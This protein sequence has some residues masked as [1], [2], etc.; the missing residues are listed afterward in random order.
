MGTQW[1]L[2]VL[3][4]P[5]RIAE[6][7]QAVLN[8]VVMQMSQWEPE[9]DISRFNRSAPSCWVM[10]P[11]EFV[12]V[13]E[14]ALAIS[15][16][17]GGAFD[18]AMGALTDMWGFG[19]ARPPVRTPDAETITLAMA[20]RGTVELDS[21]GLRARR[22]GKA[23]LDFSGIAKGYGV[24]LVAEWLL[25]QGVR[26]F[27]IEV[28]G[29]LRGHGLRPDRQPW[30]AD[31]ELPPGV[32]LPPLRVALHEMAIATSGDYRRWLDVD[33]RRHSHSI[34]PRNGQPIANGVRSVTV[35]HS[36]CMLADA[37]ATA[38]TV[39]GPEAG[40][41]LARSEGLAVQMVTTEEE[42]ISPALR[43]MLD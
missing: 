17:S 2:S 7:V 43:E 4:P 28:G 9:S 27:L 31:I 23:R 37:W 14:T 6:G 29:E 19:P 20:A 30:W 12:T 33:G 11:P 32:T 16:K 39:L 18:P 13:L 42:Y 26:H 10:L 22:T 25:A 1:R 40:M 15:A 36:R 38:L 41:A 8:R 35:L 3:S 24:D 5:D 21:L 34:D